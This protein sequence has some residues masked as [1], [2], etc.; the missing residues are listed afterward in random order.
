MFL[1]LTPKQKSKKLLFFAFI[2]ISF[3]QVSVKIWPYKQ[4][5]FK[6]KTAPSC[7]ESQELLRRWFKC[8]SCPKMAKLPRSCQA[9]CGKDYFAVLVAPSTIYL[10]KKYP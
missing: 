2:D 6:I 1:S 10:M 9:T 8:K 3:S 5:W 7:S 4:T